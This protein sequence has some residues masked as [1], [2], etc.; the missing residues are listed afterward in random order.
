MSHDSLSAWYADFFTELPNAFWRAAVPE[1][2]TAAEVG[3]VIRLAGLRPGSRVL[4]VA[5]G[6]G[7]HAL[8]LARRGCR[9]T[10]LDVSAEAVAHARAVAAGERLD[11][12]L[13]RGDMRTLPTD[14]RADAAMCMG[15]AFGYLEHA[16]TQRFLAGLAGIV[17]PG[18]TLILD[19]GF[20]AE[21]LLPNLALEE[22][23]MT[24]GGVE[25]V[26]VNE[27][28]AVNS[29]WLTSFTFRRGTQEHRG[30]SVQHVYTAAE[31]VRLVTEAGF[32]GVE[33]YGDADGTPFRFG[34]PRLLLVARRP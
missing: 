9:V 13:R 29:R 21:S 3:F 15:N 7:R 22:P 20:V 26:S 23:P 27:Y 28:D 34:S 5:C 31:V 14:V 10:G 8:E 11:L 4:D 24:F 17:V 19:Y 18:G 16:G 6:S 25:A 1:E 2:M 33:L 32:T 12:D 30:T